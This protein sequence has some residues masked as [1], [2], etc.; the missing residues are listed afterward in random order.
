MNADDLFTVTLKGGRPW[1]VRLQGG[2]EYAQRIRVAKVGSRC[3]CDYVTMTA[4]SVGI[5]IRSPE[6]LPCLPLPQKNLTTEVEQHLAQRV[7]CRRFTC[8]FDPASFGQSLSTQQITVHSDDFLREL[9]L[10]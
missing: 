2:Y 8:C 5:R 1:G 3:C 6:S 7:Y 9:F 10:G 4:T